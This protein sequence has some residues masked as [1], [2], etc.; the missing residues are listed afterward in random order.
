MSH[1]P[2]FAVAVAAVLALATIATVCQSVQHPRSVL[3]SAA[4]F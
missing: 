1:P 2:V 4:T 3:T